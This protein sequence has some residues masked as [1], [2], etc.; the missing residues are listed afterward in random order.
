[1]TDIVITEPGGGRTE[2]S[3]ED[4]RRYSLGRAQTNDI[5]LSDLS[6]SR[7]HAHLY[8]ESG[9]WVIADCGSANGTFLNGT[10]IEAPA[11]LDPGAQLMVGGCTLEVKKIVRDRGHVK[12]SDAPL[13]AQDTV[14]I[15]AADLDLDAELKE[16]MP[17]GSGAAE[18]MEIL[19][20]RLAVVEKANLELLAH[21]PMTTL[22]PKVLDLVFEA[23][24]PD[25]AALLRREDGK[26]V[27]RAMRGEWGSESVSISRTI[28][29]MVLDQRV[30]VLTADAQHDMRF[31]EA[32]SIESQGIG[33]MMAVPLWNNKDVIGLLYADSFLAARAFVSDDLK[34]LTMLA[35]VAAIQIENAILFE[36]QVEKRRLIEE[37]L[38]AAKIQQGLLPAR[39]PV[40]EG[41]D[42]IGYNMP[43]HEVGGDYYDC[44]D[45]VDGRRAIVI[46]DVAG[47][48][49]S[50]AL[51]M[52]VLQAT[53]HAQVETAPEPRKLIEGLN[54]A[55]ARSA[56][57]NRFV[58]LFYADLDPASNRLLCVNAGHAPLPVVVRASGQ[59]DEIAPGGLPLGVFETLEHGVAEVDLGR[60]DFLFACSDG[61]TDVTDPGGEMFG[62]DRLRDLLASCAGRPIAE[63]REALDV[64]L[65]AHA[66]GTAPP[67]DL[68]IVILQRR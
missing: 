2:V 46:G 59:I 36:E 41:Y 54:R 53:F 42:F 45:L 1:M 24:R 61:V 20:R 55:I 67:D 5:I 63:V 47:K 26:L 32:A 68:T 28:A 52:A 34:V 17:L 64:G 62:D 27:C 23:V 60:G 21:E 57:S 30:S 6:L 4:G 29:G 25:R 12:Y 18:V 7:R 39:P 9:H 33:S 13:A 31:A 15:T 58:T 49:M 37:A 11:R 65:K 51:L 66:H 8:L 44:L 3:L 16:R 38:A 10:R 40:I 56:P 48:G 35:N 19:K 22:L 50:A 14:T 43:C